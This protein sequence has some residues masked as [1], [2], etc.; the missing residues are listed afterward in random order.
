ML[1]KQEEILQGAGLDR[2]GLRLIGKPL[3]QWLRI[4]QLNR[5][6]QLHNEKPGRE[7]IDAALNELG[8]QFHVP[9]DQ[10]QHIPSDQP[11]IMVAN[12][13]YGVLDGLM[14]MRIVAELRDDFKIMGN[15][16]LERIDP[17]R[18][19][20]VCVNPINIYKKAYGNLGGIRETTRQLSSGKPMIVF[21]AGTVSTY[22]LRAG[23]IK[24]RTW[25][26][27]IAKL[28]L[29]YKYPV[30]PL[31]IHGGNGPAFQILGRL[32]PAI[33][34]AMQVPIAFD[35]SGKTIQVRIGQPI[36]PDQLSDYATPAALN[37]FLQKETY[38]LSDDSPR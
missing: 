25:R 3:M 33:K 8:V 17:L 16:L 35:H 21:P 32:H 4:P 7:F 15:F 1:I 18:K 29:K 22:S 27:P 26:E 20:V 12:H 13:P 37:A 28:I 14:I 31:Y 36:M 6:Y 23:R 19:W 5:I 34:L 2:P 24:D 10:M 11:F 9:P 38:K 30:V